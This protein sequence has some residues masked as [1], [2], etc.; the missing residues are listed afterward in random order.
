MRLRRIMQTSDFICPHCMYQAQL[1]MFEN[2]G[3]DEMRCKRC[4]SRFRDPNAYGMETAYA[5][6][7][8][9]RPVT[10]F[11]FSIGGKSA[12]IHVREGYLAFLVRTGGERQWIQ[13]R[14]F[15]LADVSDE[16]QL[17]YVCLSP[18]ICWGI[19][20]LKAFG[21]YGSARLSI[22]AGCVMRFCEAEGQILS[23]EA[24]LKQSVNRHIAR[25]IQTE[26]NR[27]STSLLENR[28][29]Y[30]GMTGTLEDGVSLVRIEPRGFRNAAG[31]T[32]FFPSYL[33]AA[34]APDAAEP[35]S[36]YRPPVEI[37]HPPK[38]AYTVKSGVEEVFC[39]STAKLRRHKAG[40][41]VDT[42]QLR[43]V[44]TLIR[45]KSKTFDYP[46]GWGIY[47][48]PLASHGFYSAQGVISFYI[49]STERFGL[50]LYK[51]KT[52]RNFEFQFFTDILKKELAEALREITAARIGGQ[53]FQPQKITGYLSALS[54]DLT[55]A[56]NGESASAKGPVFRQYGLRVKQAD[57]LGVNFYDV[58]R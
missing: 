53:N 49:D 36:L 41:S 46:F 44:E 33:T 22:S 5:D 35:P 1:S 9:V 15:R 27:Q 2:V 40:E 26:I 19:G 11:P 3:G 55:N 42:E 10:H 39:F 32:G 47:N 43:G 6:C 21:A 13:E 37:I 51:A 38:S 48:Q 17:Y 34:D 31:K 16:T 24:R 14:D 28:D 56:L 20:G 30:M 25:C 45:Y 50:L 58:R 57:I 54:V 7:D 29:V 4:R 18:R 52:W 8:S 12:L 23:L